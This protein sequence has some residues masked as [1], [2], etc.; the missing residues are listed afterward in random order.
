M[1]NC[2][3]GTGSPKTVGTVPGKPIM[4]NNRKINNIMEKG[5]K[6]RKS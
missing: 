1:N 5:N 4:N 6:E 3:E 2:V